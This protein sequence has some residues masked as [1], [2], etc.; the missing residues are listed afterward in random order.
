MHYFLI[1]FIPLASKD[2]YL[3]V[4][5]LDIV[6]T[7]CFEGFITGFIYGRSGAWN[8]NTHRT[9]NL[10]FL[11]LAIIALIFYFTER[12]YRHTIHKIYMLFRL[13]VTVVSFI[14][15][16]LVLIDI[17][18][19]GAPSKTDQLISLIGYGCFNILNLYWSLELLKICN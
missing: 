8:Y 5:I 18:R 12:T 17:I 16:I 2:F 10:I 1:W 7:L 11:I 14:F 19:G 6:M 9:L 3:I 13:F 15:L 4:N